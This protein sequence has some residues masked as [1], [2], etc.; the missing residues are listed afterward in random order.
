MNTLPTTTHSKEILSQSDTPISPKKRWGHKFC[1]GLAKNI[2]DYF[3]T[4]PL[5][6]VEVDVSIEQQP[7]LTI[8]GSISQSPQNSDVLK[9]IT[10][11]SISAISLGL[12]GSLQV[13]GAIYLPPIVSPLVG[14]SVAYSTKK[15]EGKSQEGAHASIDASTDTSALD[16]S[17]S[18]ESKSAHHASTGT[19]LS[20]SAN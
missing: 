18:L 4:H 14:E 1:M 19:G 6:P 2:Q 3:T 17:T 9:K 13:L 16:T 15:F 12:G 11:T 10:D 7:A 8:K 5:K 20:L